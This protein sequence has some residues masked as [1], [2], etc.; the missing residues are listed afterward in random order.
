MLVIKNDDTNITIIVGKC[1]RENTE[2]VNKYNKS[3]GVWYHLKDNPS[4]HIIVINE[5]DP[6]VKVEITKG[7]N[8]QIGDL[9]KSNSKYKGKN[10]LIYTEISN[11][12]TTKTPGLVGFKQKKINEF[13]Y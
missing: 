3:A 10:T 4:P 11:V 13:T 1:A 8:I 9:M 7:L 5:I 2:L 12:K 6:N